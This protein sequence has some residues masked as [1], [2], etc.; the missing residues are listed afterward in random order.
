MTIARLSDAELLRRVLE[1]A[2]T[3][4]QARQELEERHYQAVRTFAG[5]LSP[6][7]GDVLAGQA[8]EQT[9]RLETRDLDGAVRPRALSAVLHSAAGWVRT[10]QWSTL[11]PDF[12]AWLG[13]SDSEEHDGGAPLL[14]ATS[15]SSTM[16]R[17]FDTLPGRSQEVLWHHEVEH[18]DGAVIERLLGEVPETVPQL[19]KRAQQELFNSYVQIY[20]D[21]ILD[22][23]CLRFDRMLLAYVEDK[24]RNTTADLVAHLKG[25]SHCAKAAADLGCRRSEFGTLLAEALLPWGHSKYAASAS[26][27]RPPAEE[28]SATWAAEARPS[29]AILA[30]ADGAP[31]EPEEP[32]W[33]RVLGLLVEAVRARRGLSSNA[34]VRTETS[35]TAAPSVPATPATP[36]TPSTSGFSPRAKRL[37]LAAGLVCL[38][39]LIIGAFAAGLWQGDDDSG[40]GRGGDSSST[41]PGKSPGP[42]SGDQAESRV[43]GAELEWPFDE[44]DEGDTPDT[45]GNGIDG[46]LDGDPPP[47][48]LPGGG[49]LRFT[50]GQEQSVTSDGPAIDTEESFSVSARVRLSGNDDASDPY[51]EIANQTTAQRGGFSLRYD[52]DRNQWQT[53]LWDTDYVITELASGRDFVPVPNQ[54]THLTAVHDADED[55]MR[56]YVNG[57]VADSSEVLGDEVFDAET[58]FTVG[59]GYLKRGLLA[60]FDGTI[61]DVRAFGRALSRDEVADLAGTA[62]PS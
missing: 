56:L 62:T 1:D 25:C 4:P 21:T 11:A 48:L 9:V 32:N 60:H 33:R 2:E 22:D 37:A 7:A 53:V 12:A 46:M 44:L 31:A 36:A 10:D 58:D 45:S 18:D 17:A 16:A 14:S 52:S 38:C 30:S 61:K 13:A 5:I 55:E 26:R 34:P 50:E 29:S 57:D 20:Q 47:E 6:S 49:G 24:S 39:S 51:G 27:R 40:T 54:W 8:W 35:A 42:G 28:S 23:A 15:A 19:L 3:A 59:Q 41:G 43:G